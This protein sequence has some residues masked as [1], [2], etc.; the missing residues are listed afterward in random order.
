V[1]IQQTLI[2]ADPSSEISCEGSV[3]VISNHLYEENC[4]DKSTGECANDSAD[5]S[6]DEEQQ[7]IPSAAFQ[8]SNEDDNQEDNYKQNLA[9]FNNFNGFNSHDNERESIIV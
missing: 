2:G 3:K 6:A 1:P 5:F 8:L 7:L 4:A 9:Q